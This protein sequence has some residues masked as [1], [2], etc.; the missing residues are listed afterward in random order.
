MRTALC[1]L[2]LAASALAEIR[3]STDFEGGNAEVVSLDQNTKTLRIM[4]ELHEGRGWPCWWYLKLDGLTTGETITLE[5]QAQT[6]PFRENTVLASAWC[7]PKHAWLSLDGE[8]WS[9]SEAGTLSPEKVMRYTLKPT[10]AS[11]RLAWGPPFV[12][13]DAE[14][15]LATLK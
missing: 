5:V 9:P 1:C 7:Q 2:F 13:K 3:V 12:P 8:T 14:K 15:L 4:P 10:T 11:L 6:K